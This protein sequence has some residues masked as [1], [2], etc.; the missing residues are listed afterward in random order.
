LPNI[1]FG[2]SK[3]VYETKDTH[4]LSANTLSIQSE[5]VWSSVTGDVQRA[6]DSINQGAAWQ[7]S[8]QR[9]INAFNHFRGRLED[10]YE[11]CGVGLL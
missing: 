4:C 5:Y 3:R 11:K 7:S 1:G 6:N 8:A 2:R 9:F 10:A